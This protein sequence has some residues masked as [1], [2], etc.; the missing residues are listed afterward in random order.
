[1]FRFYLLIAV[2]LSNIAAAQES[3]I[4]SAKNFFADSQQVWK[5]QTPIL[6]MFST[7]GCRFCETVKEDII[8]PMSMMDE[9]RQK[10][11]IRHVDASN[12]DDIINFYNEDVTNN[13]FSFQSAVNFFPTVLLVNQYGKTLEKLIGLPSE[14]FYWSELDNLIDSAR[15]KLTTKMDAKL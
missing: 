15:K 4:P 9:Y 14:E 11:I 13:E 2:F 6:I 3:I 1:M 7:I 8:L 5:N 10:I 12:F